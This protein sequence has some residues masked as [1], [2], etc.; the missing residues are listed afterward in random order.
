MCRPELIVMLTYNDFTVSDASAIFERCKE[1]KAC[2][3]GMKEHPLPPQEMKQLF[4]KMKS[5]GKTTFL[6]VVAYS[7]EEG[8]AGA[9][10]AALCGCDVLMGTS[11]AES[12]SDFCR[13]N[14][15]RYMPF[16]GHVSGRPSVL[17][18]SVESMVAEAREYVAKGAYGID[19]LGYRYDGDALGMIRQFL[20]QIEVPVCLA[21]SIDSYSRLEEVKSVAPWSFTIGSAFFDEKFLIGNEDKLASQPNRCG[22]DNPLPRSFTLDGREDRY[23]RFYRQIDLV[24]DFFG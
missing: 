24:C 8:M 15:I 13:A 11:F 5:Y 22:E 1:S 3:W 21:G 18:G 10:L 17:S 9:E 7:E 14:Q 16:V 19:L 4:A 6:E 23:A 12:I 2:C 20:N